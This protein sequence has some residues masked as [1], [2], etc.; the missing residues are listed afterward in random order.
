MLQIQEP[1]SSP[2]S[3]Q[4]GSASKRRQTPASKVKPSANSEALRKT[5]EAREQSR[6]QLIEER[7]RAMRANAN[8]P[9]SAVEIFVPET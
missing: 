6:K 1:K 5:R 4:N 7:R 8:K 3:P 2:S 9:D